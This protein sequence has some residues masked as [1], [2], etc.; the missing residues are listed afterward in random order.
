MTRLTERP[1]YG[2]GSG[3]L[4]RRYV[5]M[6]YR[7]RYFWIFSRWYITS[8]SGI[9]YP[10]HYCHTDRGRQNKKNS[11]IRFADNEPVG[12]RSEIVSGTR[13]TRNQNRY[14]SK[15]FRFTLHEYLYF[16][17]FFVILMIIGLDRIKKERSN[18]S[19]EPRRKTR[20]L[21]LYIYI[22]I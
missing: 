11:I 8:G 17:F 5:R 10:R 20:F 15:R 1:D 6:K 12:K 19:R 7:I 22:Y 2:Y 14:D 4:H 21:F 13:L 3:F 16:D 9:G 18:G